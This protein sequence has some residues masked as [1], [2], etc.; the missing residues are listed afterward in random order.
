MKKLEKELKHKELYKVVFFV[1]KIRSYCDHFL[2]TSFFFLKHFAVWN[3]R[4]SNI[5]W[6]CRSPTRGFLLSSGR[7]LTSSL[8]WGFCNWLRRRS[9]LASRGHLGLRAHWLLC[10]RYY[11]VVFLFFSVS[12]NQIGFSKAWLSFL[13]RPWQL[14][15][16]PAK[17]KWSLLE[18]SC[19]VRSPII[20]IA[21]SS[22]S[23]RNKSG[24][25]SPCIM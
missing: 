15:P 10:T 7:A 3:G 17:S 2:S 8:R 24:Q 14:L 5:G 25:K 9:L 19:C 18:G 23:T 12:S 13:F 21:S 1:I 22:S 4:M 6:S 11:N 16:S 20:S